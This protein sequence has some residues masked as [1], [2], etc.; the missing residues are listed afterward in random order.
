LEVAVVEVAVKDPLTLALKEPCVENW[1]KRLRPVT[2]PTY[3]SILKH[4]LLWLWKQPGWGAK[5]PSEL[6]DFQENARKGREAKLLLGLM[7]D[8][9]QE[10]GGTYS[11]MQV[12]L[13]HLRS[14]FFL[15]DVEIPPAPGWNPEPTREPVQGRLTFDQVRDIVLHAKP[16]D[17]TVFLTMLQGVM[18]K[19]RF[20]AFNMKYAEALTARLKSGDLDTPFRVDF[21]TGRKRNKRPFFTYLYH[22]ALFSWKTYFDRIRG[23]WPQKGEPMALETRDRP[24][25]KDAPANA[26]DTIARQLKYKPPV[27]AGKGDK[28]YRTGVAV[29]DAFRDVVKS[30]LQTAKKK[31]FDMTC[32]QFWMGHKIDPY[33]YNRFTENEPE[34][35]LE[36]AR[37]ASEY[38]NII[39]SS[40]E[41][42]T[43]LQLQDRIQKLELA[44]R[45]LQDA[46]GYKVVG[47]AEVKP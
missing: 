1:L 30:R 39:T 38:L 27:G 3:K 13:S 45:A 32:V 20:H 29:H 37:I 47:E 2:R 31:G 21:L 35:V 24:L 17:Q 12:R 11:S 8:F 7:K 44:I 9:V 6:L 36:N 25:S 22:D 28:G 5:R 23:S 19:E 42:A 34:Y 16:R 40:T 41:S 43:N 33:N 15:N 10:T 4:W 14:L 26:F 18:D 46:S